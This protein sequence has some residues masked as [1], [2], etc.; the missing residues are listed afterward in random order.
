MTLAISEDSGRSW[1]IRR[2]L[3]VGDGYC[4]SNNSR[5][6]LNREYSYPSI[7]QGPD[8]A[9]NIAYTYFRQAIKYV[10]VD[11][12]WAYEGTH[13]ARAAWTGA[14]PAAQCRWPH[15]VVTGCSSGIG[16]AIA[17]RLLADGWR[18]TGLSRSEP[19]LGG[20]PVAARGP[21]G[22]GVAGRSA[23]RTWAGW[24]P[25]STPPGS[26]GP[27]CW[28]SWIRTRWPGCS[29]SMWRPPAPW[30]TPWCRTMPDGGRVLLVGSRTSTG[31]PGKSQYAATKAA[32]LGHG[33]DVGAGT[34][35]ARHH[36]E[37]AV[38]GPTD[39]PM[40]ADPGRAATPPKLPALGPA[41]GPGGR[42]GARRF[43]AGRPR[44]VHHRPE[45]RDLRRRVPVNAPVNRRRTGPNS[46]R[47]AGPPPGT[48][49]DAQQ[50]P[51]ESQR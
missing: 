15:A 40:L 22:P 49:A 39:T 27:P 42:G 48:A 32:L 23:S 17:A 7:H 51:K 25:W 46:M 2:N 50:P 44:E 6:G 30:R 19:S 1:P 9:L 12:Q 14:A 13:H 8:G 11:P 37:R 3:D 24:T 29:P 4:L 5:D 45:L 16:K 28:A 43:P 41:G 21:L 33:P 35:A 36:G 31:S 26:S 20:L 34:G 38:P 47:T 10:R 18:V